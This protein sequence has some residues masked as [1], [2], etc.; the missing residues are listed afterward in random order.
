[1]EQ[2]L[3]A[4]HNASGNEVA[5]GAAALLVAD[6]GEVFWRH[7][8]LVGKELH[9]S[10]VGFVACQKQQEFVEQLI[11]LTQHTAIAL[12]EVLA[13]A[14]KQVEGKTFENAHQRF[15][16]VVDLWVLN[17]KHCQLVVLQHQLALV[18]RELH[19]R[20]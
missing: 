19:H 18:L 10:L 9:A 4:A 14:R 2:L 3:Y 15:A 5:G 16:A 7:K 20:I 13:H 11:A 12:G 17:L 1:M 6:A 8:Q